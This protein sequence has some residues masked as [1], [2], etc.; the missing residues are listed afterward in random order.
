MGQKGLNQREAERTSR[1]RDTGSESPLETFQKVTWKITIVEKLSK[2]HA[3]ACIKRVLMSL[4]Y[5]GG[6]SDST[7]LHYK[8][9]NQKPTVRNILLLMRFNRLSNI[10]DYFQRYWLPSLT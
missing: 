1:G 2:I 4:P 7:R 5:N 9:T 8:I 6:N 3:Y 10:K